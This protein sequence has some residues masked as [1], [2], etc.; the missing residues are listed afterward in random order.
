MNKLEKIITGVL[1]LVELGGIAALTGIALKR[2]QAAYEAE[3]KCINLELENIH[4][5]VAISMLEHDLK[6][7]KEKYDVKDEDLN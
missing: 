5:D 3:M 6:V 2:N 7:I 4:L 1:T